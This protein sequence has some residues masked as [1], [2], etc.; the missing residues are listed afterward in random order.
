ML[1]LCDILGPCDIANITMYDILRPYDIVLLLYEQFSEKYIKFDS[2]GTN[3]RCKMNRTI[4]IPK[5]NLT[6][7][8]HIL[9]PH[10]YSLSS[11]INQWEVNSKYHCS[12]ESFLISL[13]V[14]FSHS[15][16]LSFSHNSVSVKACMV[17]YDTH[18]SC[19]SMPV[20]GRDCLSSK[21]IKEEIASYVWMGKG[22]AEPLLLLSVE[23]SFNQSPDQ[24][25]QPLP[26]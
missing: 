18:A 17:R 25:L 22:R 11:L 1:M 10:I 5:L 2:C 16:G 20:N 19:F 15:R 8:S 12:K 14:P 26:S 21:E 24:Y 3:V 4:S 13:S 6:Y 9:R 23:T 7:S